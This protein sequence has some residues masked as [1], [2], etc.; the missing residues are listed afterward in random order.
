[1]SSDED[2]TTV[3]GG[4]EQSDTHVAQETVSRADVQ[5]DGR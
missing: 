3:K 4:K 5:M 2:R 1:M